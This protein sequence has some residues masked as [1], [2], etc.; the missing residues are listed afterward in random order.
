MTRSSPVFVP[1]A[2]L[3]ATE[4][5]CA[6]LDGELVPLGEGYVCVDAPNTSFARASSLAPI[7]IDTR[8]IISDRSA[9]WVWG[10]GPMPV[11]VSTCVSIAARIP[12]PNRR[13]LRAREVVIGDDERVMLGG[14]AVTSP[15]RTLV[16]LARHD[17]GDDLQQ[18]LACGLRESRID[19]DILFSALSGRIN[20]S[21]VRTARQRILA[22]IA[23][24]TLESGASHAVRA[25]L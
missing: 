13:R 25:S 7:V 10:W 21:F 1:D 5:R 6:A 12:S 14:V 19:L 9:A 16:D 3:S 18:L 20:L 11:A 23:Q 8:V 24:A 17:T 4:L 15:V 2:R 22:A